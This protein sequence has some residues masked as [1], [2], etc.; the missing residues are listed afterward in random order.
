MLAPR[1][2]RSRREHASKEDGEQEKQ[3]IA[4]RMECGDARG[5]QG[6]QHLSAAR[7]DLGRHGEK[8]EE[9]EGG[10]QYRARE[11]EVEP[12]PVEGPEARQEVDA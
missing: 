8:A 6:R 5:V 1:T 9:A 3:A 4:Q 12:R 10:N 2:Q 11:E 7:L